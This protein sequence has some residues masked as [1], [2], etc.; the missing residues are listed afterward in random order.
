MALTESTANNTSLI[1]R[2]QTTRKSIV[3]LGNNGTDRVDSKQYIADFQATN[4]EEE[5]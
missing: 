3:Y 4:H 2:Q 1:S 5:H